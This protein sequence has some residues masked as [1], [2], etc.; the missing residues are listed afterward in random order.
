M[1]KHI[2][3]FLILFFTALLCNRT[4]AQLQHDDSPTPEIDQLL[5]KIDAVLQK[6]HIPGLM[7]SIVKQDSILFSG[8][9]GYA[10]LEQKIKVDH[11]TQ[12]HLAS[13]TKFFVAMGIQK[14][15][16][17]GKLNLNDRLQAI[18]PELPFT[19]KWE[20]MHPVRLVHLLE[21]TAGFEDIQLNKM[22]NTTGKPLK[23]IDGVKAV[24]SSLNS[25]WKPGEMMSYSNPGYNVL[26]YVIENVS[27]VPWDSYINQVLFKPLGMDNTRFDLN[28]EKLP[29]YAR[30]YHFSDGNY[31]LLP[32]YGPSG[33][34]A[35]GSVVS[36]A[37]DMAKFMH[38]LLN[39]GTNS[40]VDLLNENDISEME[41]VHSTLAGQHGLQTGYALGNDL[42]PNNK[43]ITFRGHNGKGEGFVSWLFFNRQAG[44]AYTISANCNTNLW[45]VSQLIEDFL[46]KDIDFPTMNSVLIDQS[47]IVPMLGYYQFMNPKNEKWEFFK[48]IF[49]GINLLA[50][51]SD[52]LIVDK[53]NGQRDS[54]I[55]IGNG[56]FRLKG[57]IIPSLIIGND[58]EGRP[59]FQG[60][61]NGFY[62]KTS[63]GPIL[64][65][66]ILIYL[67]LLAALLSI[68]CTIVGIPLVLF[69]KIKAIDLSIIGLPAIGT[70]CFSLA[71]RKMGL[72]DAANK[73]LFTTLNTT[74]F[75]IFAG[76]LF[77]GMSVVIGAYLL[78]KRWPQ[79]R[80]KWIKFFLAFNILFLFY[81]VVLFSI[82]GWIG[83]PIWDM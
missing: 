76:M 80:K 41:K 7:I 16:A 28:G 78:Y 10:D 37:T 57:N 55:H 81:L 69:R 77:F 70:I 66:K 67:G 53:G 59:F 60:Y 79:I 45:P 58:N 34:G 20:P 54:L 22:V 48:R 47:K 73:E 17:A 29:S 72:T 64:F 51:D 2:R 27:G 32:L 26:G 18:A 40:S 46:T 62:S 63:Y 8:G 50:I 36:N 38:Y 25:R 13:I 75:S 49:G 30:G 42:F 44:L 33:N 39:A 83:I 21:H 11:T 15:I 3:S 35:S 1:N 61:G 74:S 24:E 56:I 31:T 14:L 43:K 12:F 65:Q 23:G 9:L 19:N 68:I 5:K 82:H 71:Y 4:N 52:K 6:E